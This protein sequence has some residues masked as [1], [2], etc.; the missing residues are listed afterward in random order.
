MEQRRARLDD[1]YEPVHWAANYDDLAALSACISLDSRQA[2]RATSRGFTPLHIC[3]LNNS[4]QCARSLLP[5]LPDAALNAV[6]CWGETAL[7]LASSCNA[8]DVRDLLLRAGADPSARDSWGQTASEAAA[9]AQL[10]RLQHDA[11]VCNPPTPPL[12]TTSFNLELKTAILSRKL[13]S[14][15]PPAIRGIFHDAPPPLPSPAPAQT[16]VRCSRRSLSSLVE[17]PGDYHAVCSLLQQHDVDAAGADCFGLTGVCARA[18][19][20]RAHLFTLH[21]Q[22]PTNLRRGTIALCFSCC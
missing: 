10:G 20:Q 7:H 18:L 22:P 16:N 19:A 11:V 6:N 14:V 3:A 9:A 2:A 12:H 8:S 13:R 17:Y 15:P 1:G 5:L 21:M 4:V